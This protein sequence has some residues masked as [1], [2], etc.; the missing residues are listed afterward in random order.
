MSEVDASVVAV[1]VDFHAGDA[2]VDCVRSLQENGVNDIVVVENGEAGSA[3]QVLEPR[4]VQLVEPGMNLGY[5]RGVNRGA[6]AAT[7]EK[8]YLL[9]SN[10][11][12]LVHHGAVEALVR[13]LDEHPE[14]AV[15]GPR[16]VATDGSI[17]PSQ[18]V[19]PNVW[20]AGLHALL[21]PIWPDNPATRRYRSRR[22]DGGVDWVSGAFFLIRRE[23]F[24]AIGGFDE[25]YFMFAEDMALC[26]QVRELGYTVSAT[27]D[28]VVTH[29]E[30]LSRAGASRAMLIA[31]HRSAL[32]FEWQTARGI[33]RLLAPLAS[34]VLG[35]RLFS[36]LVSSRRA[37]EDVQRP[38]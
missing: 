32:R 11:D 28:A 18:R 27:D 21:G 12:V 34:L 26:W 6:A 10:P 16:I 29:I 15:V 17:Y 19:F 36:V 30:G 4:S 23:I 7:K 25:R 13:F 8:R 22:S 37:G 33:R 5:G 35:L 2:L 9:V 24:E 1:I 3:A 31:H 38:G 14:A 20:L